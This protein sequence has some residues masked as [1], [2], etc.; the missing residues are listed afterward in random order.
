MLR[1]GL[2][3]SRLASTLRTGLLALLLGAMFATSIYLLVFLRRPTEGQCL[4]DLGTVML[5][6]ERSP[7]SALERR[8]LG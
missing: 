3:A 1:T 5:D 7:R 2:L 4:G 6:F 8:R